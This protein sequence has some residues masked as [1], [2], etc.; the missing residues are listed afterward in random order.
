MR[1]LQLRRKGICGNLLE[2]LISFLDSRKQRV[3]LNCHCSSWGFINEYYKVLKVLF[4]DVC[5][6]YLYKRSNGKS[7]IKPKIFC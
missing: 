2:L 3:L 1:D 5:F 7:S 4:S 6:F